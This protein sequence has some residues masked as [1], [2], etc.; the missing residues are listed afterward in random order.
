MISEEVEE[1]WQE[2]KTNITKTAE[3][4]LGRTMK[5]CRSKDWFD[6]EC[7]EARMQKNLA[8]VEWINTRQQPK[9]KEYEIKQN[10]VNIIYV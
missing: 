3:E 8:R 7:E 4:I 2:I 9:R 5:G 10:I 6:Q 1:V